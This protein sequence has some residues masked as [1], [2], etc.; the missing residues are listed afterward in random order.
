MMY[1][2]NPKTDGSGIICAIPQKGICPQGC[3][4][5]FF[6]SGRS[7]LEPLDEN[8]P[9]MPS[10]IEAT[11]R[12]VRVNDGNDSNVERDLVLYN[13]QH[14]R[15]KF[16]NTSIPKPFD[17]PFVLTVNPGKITN[18]TFSELDPIPKTLMFARFRANTWNTPEMDRAIAYYTSKGVPVV[19]TFMAYWKYEGSIPKSHVINYIMRKRTINEYLAI[20]TS[21]WR[22]VM[23][24]YED[25]PLVHSCG[26]IEGE[27]GKSGCKFCGNCLREYYATLERMRT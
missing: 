18:V 21:A 1:K 22:R 13:T 25:N 20:T 19:L 9:N 16:Y 8:T 2:V 3:P 27:K 17:L 15:H 11:N 26:K 7:Y 14:Y 6:Q 10:E 5:C 4:D 12:V 24:R 23:R